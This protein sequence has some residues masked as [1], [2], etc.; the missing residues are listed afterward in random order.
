M[1]KHETDIVVSVVLCPMFSLLTLQDGLTGERGSAD[2]HSVPL[3]GEQQSKL[4]LDT[5]PVK[6]SEEPG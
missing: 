5:K 2:V 3:V 1:A 6:D 4:V